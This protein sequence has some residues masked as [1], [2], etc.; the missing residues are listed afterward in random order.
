MTKSGKVVCGV[1]RKPML[2]DVETLI[3]AFQSHCNV[4]QVI[5]SVVTDGC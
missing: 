3:K 1:H 5:G 4:W 2:R